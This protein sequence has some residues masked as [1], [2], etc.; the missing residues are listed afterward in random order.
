MTKRPDATSDNGFI[1]KNK[2][3]LKLKEKREKK[4]SVGGFWNDPIYPLRLT[5]RHIRN[6]VC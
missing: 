1:L 6:K 3:K 4:D 2:N 5:L